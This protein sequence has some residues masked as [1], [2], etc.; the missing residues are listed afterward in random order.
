MN[1]W[2]TALVLGD[3]LQTAAHFPT[4]RPP[5]A[6]MPDACLVSA[7]SAPSPSLAPFGGGGYPEIA[8]HLQSPPI[9]FP[10]SV[11]SL[12]FWESIPI[13][14]SAL[15]ADPTSTPFSDLQRTLRRAQIIN[16]HLVS[17]TQLG[18]IKYLSAAFDARPHLDLSWDCCN[19][20]TLCCLGW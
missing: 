12:L 5:Q 19:V 14:E 6:L 1:S 13:L 16:T 9:P 2:N 15:G 10:V 11:P 8:S 3:A 7:L 4:C 18:L 20:P 17:W